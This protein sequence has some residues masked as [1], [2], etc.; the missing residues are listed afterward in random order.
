MVDL[1]K[2]VLGRRKNGIGVSADGLT[3]AAEPAGGKDFVHNLVGAGVLVQSDN[4]VMKLQKKTS[5]DPWKMIPLGDMM[6]AEF[7]FFQITVGFQNTF[8]CGELFGIVKIKIQIS[9][10]TVFRDR[11]AVGKAQPL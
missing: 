2:H 7:F 5:A 6:V 9:E 4:A 3:A 11:I 1:V 8:C 10:L